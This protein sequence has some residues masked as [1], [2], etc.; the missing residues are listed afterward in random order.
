MVNNWIKI[1]MLKKSELFREKPKE[2][3]ES[4]E[5]L[6]GMIL[7]NVLSCPFE[8]PAQYKVIAPVGSGAYGIV[9]A[10]KD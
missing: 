2:E 1:E 5:M 8:L 3:I 4:K 7:W 9:V 6:N 10:A